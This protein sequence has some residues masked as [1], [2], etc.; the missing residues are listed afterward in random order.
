MLGLSLWRKTRLS[1]DDKNSWEKPKRWKKT[2]CLGIR[3]WRIGSLKGRD[4]LS[5][6]SYQLQLNTHLW[7]L[8]GIHPSKTRP[9]F[10][11]S[12]KPTPIHPWKTNSNDSYT[13]I[14][15]GNLI[16]SNTICICTDLC[17]LSRDGKNWGVVGMFLWIPHDLRVV[18][19]KVFEIEKHVY[20]SKTFFIS[21]F[22]V[23]L[24]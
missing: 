18:K 11:Q 22:V 1:L 8:S 5:Q 9:S 3:A 2:K 4:Y 21:F 23:C 20:I 7:M 19:R 12:T 16:R 17:F 10:S 13:L 14:P 6:P 15:K 24:F